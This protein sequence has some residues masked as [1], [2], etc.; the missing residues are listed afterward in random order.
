LTSGSS[1]PVVLP[2]FGNYYFIVFEFAIG[3]FSL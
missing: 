1:C 2:V 3:S